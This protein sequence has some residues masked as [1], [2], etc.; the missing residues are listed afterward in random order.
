MNRSSQLCF[1]GLALCYLSFSPSVGFASTQT[2]D[3]QVDSHGHYAIHYSLH[4]WAFE[5]DVP[6]PQGVLTHETVGTD[7]VGNYR[8]VSFTPNGDLHGDATYSIK[9]YA[10]KSL[11]IFSAE[12]RGVPASSSHFPDFHIFPIE[13]QG[14]SYGQKEFAPTI[15]GLTGDAPWSFVASDGAGFILSPANH[16]M[17]S[18][19]FKDANGAISVGIEPQVQDGS[20]NSQ[21]LKVMSIL[22]FGS[23]MNAAY[24]NWGQALTKI[25]GKQNPAND[26]DDVLNTLGYWTDNR[27]S[28]WYNYDLSLGYEGTL[29]G[30]KKE[31]LAHGLRLGHLQI[32]SWWYLKGGDPTAAQPLPVSWKHANYNHGIYLY[33]AA[34]ELFP[35]G[36]VA[37]Q[38]E[39]GL[40]LVTHAR[41]IDPSSPYASEY[42]LSNQ[43]STDPAYWDMIMKNLKANGVLIYEQDW[44]NSKALPRLDRLSD[45]DEFLD[46]MSAAAERYGIGLQYCMPLARHFLQGSKYSNLRTIRTSGDGFVRSKWNQ[47]LYGSRLASALGIW[48]WADVSF[49]Q[50]RENILIATLSGGIVGVGDRLSQDSSPTGD[51]DPHYC[52]QSLQCN[53]LQADNLRPAARADGVVVKPDTSLVPTDSSYRDLSGFAAH[54]APMV[55]VAT[56]LVGHGSPMAAYVFVYGQEPN[57][58]QTFSLRPQELGFSSDIYVYDYFKR[59]GQRVKKSGVF[60]R[61]ASASG[62]YYIA[63][64]LSSSH[65]ALLGDL[66][67]YSSMGRKRIEVKATTPSPAF[68]VHFSSGEASVTITAFDGSNAQT[69]AAPDRFRLHGPAGVSVSSKFDP[70]TKLISWTLT[71]PAKSTQQ[72]DDLDFTV[73]VKPNSMR[74]K[75]SCIVCEESS[76][77]IKKPGYWPGFLLTEI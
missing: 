30:I 58:T 6:A 2:I 25:S 3:V 49:S 56:T 14:L 26:A 70:V 9:S 73:E 37:F 5:G 48:P 4:A 68:T 29:L 19:C 27:S 20:A 44:M 62:T 63:A 40:P 32:D 34:P 54:S 76:L 41:W 1:L 61:V 10:E 60:S 74:S 12:S 31:F 66:S 7:S 11:V 36:L 23:G 15:L 71:R 43:V 52:S 59:E 22:A 72:S 13:V 17:V 8:D 18:N 16:F 39:V 51:Y 67:L 69:A 57:P 75:V 38:A 35:K 64:P 50:D 53:S 45:G 77:G 55:A 33:E 21:N 24:Q 47:F 46:G 42:E 28:Y 65:L